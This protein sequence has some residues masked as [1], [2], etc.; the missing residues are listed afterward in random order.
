[1][2]IRV[3]KG[4]VSWSILWTTELFTSIMLSVSNRVLDAIS[5]FAS[6]IA[7]FCLC[8]HVVWDGINSHFDSVFLNKVGERG[9]ILGVKV[10]EH[11]ITIRF[12]VDY[13]R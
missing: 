7:L 1:M 11:V 12:S 6:S 9:D 3:S 4:S 10:A 13:S 5:W 2:R 8:H